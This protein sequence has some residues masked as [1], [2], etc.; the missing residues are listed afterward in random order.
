MT[1]EKRNHCC[2]EIQLQPV[3]E[4][5]PPCLPGIGR[6]IFSRF[7]GQRKN[8]RGVKRRVGDV[9]QLPRGFVCYTP[10]GWT[11]MEVPKAIQTELIITKPEQE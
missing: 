9:W 10:M 11:Q 2:H 1:N 4:E 7:C 8:L 6:S 5:C 3:S